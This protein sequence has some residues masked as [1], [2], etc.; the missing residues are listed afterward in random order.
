MSRNGGAFP[1][2]AP[3]L[4]VH[5]SP[6]L[7]DNQSE[8]GQ[9]R[10]ATSIS[11]FRHHEAETFRFFIE[12]PSRMKP[13]VSVCEF[14]ACSLFFDEPVEQVEDDRIHEHFYLLFRAFCNLP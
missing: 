9:L 5:L 11:R 12:R 6:Q 2:T 8:R 13:L 14:I 10:D 4:S 7:A 3:F 1:Q